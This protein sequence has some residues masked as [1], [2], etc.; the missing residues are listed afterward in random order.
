MASA[1]VFAYHNVGV[2]ALAVLLD[3]GVDVRL[4]VTHR[5]NPAEA[6]WFA[7]VAE[8]AARHGL[9]CITP[10]DAT[11]AALLDECRA[12]DA[13]F[14]FS[15]YYRHMLP[16]PLL[17]VARRGAFNLHGSL[18]PKYR[19]RAPVNWAVL[20]G[21]RETGASLHVMEAKPDA[22]AIVDQFAVPILGDDT[23]RQV[24]DKVTLAAEIV[25][26][27]SLPR[28]IAGTARFTPQQQLPGQYFG[29]RKPE[30]GR[31]APSASA[32]QIH[33]LV[34]AVAPPEYP[35]A[36]FDAGGA[37]LVI[38]STQRVAGGGATVSTGASFALSAR[39]GVLWLDAVD[40]GRLRV[41]AAALAGRL[42]VAADFIARFGNV[43]LRP[44]A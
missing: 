37:R 7:S 11:S 42:L 33:N 5:D 16:A 25:V 12:A 15:F 8:L 4:V 43:P 21:E 29:G 18:L 22:G 9:R 17:A 14:L 28:L 31:I 24:F 39:D 3:A 38:V 13:D 26:A 30:D 32:A 19:G 10:E 44:D 36:F 6:I 41:F 27:R 1:I 40:G 34:R 20:H 23:A 35:G 2:R